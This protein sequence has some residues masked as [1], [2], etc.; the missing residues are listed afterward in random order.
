MKEKLRP[1]FVIVTLIF[2]ALACNMPGNS[3]GVETTPGLPP[4]NQTLTALFAI[5]TQATPTNTLPPI[6]TA[7]NAAPPAAATATTAPS[8]TQA[9]S[10]STQPT[11]TTAPA[12][13]KAPAGATATIPGVRPRS[14]VVAKF[15]SSPPTI[16]GDWSEWKDHGTEYPATNV[17]FGKENWANEDD[18]AGSFYVGWDNTNLYIAVKVRDDQYAQNASGENIYKGDCIEVLLDTKLRDDFFYSELSADDFQLGLSP[19]RPDVNGTREAYLWF[20]TSIAGSK[21]S[22]KIGALNQSGVWRLEA[23][24]PWSVFETT[25]VDGMHMGFG[26]SVSDNDNTGTNIQ[27]SMVSNVAGRR[28]TDPTTWG[29]LLLSK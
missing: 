28:L 6:I 23:A 10:G 19:G 27:Q 14:A 18:L 7:T 26:L 24:I 11:A 8:A 20:P 4:V 12:A 17:V 21:S 2:A 9:S 16:D 22:V 15:F 3:A 1:L 29:D 5:S 25:P 13:T